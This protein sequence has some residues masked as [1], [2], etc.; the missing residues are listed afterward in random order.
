MEVNSSMS[1]FSVLVV[2][3]REMIINRQN[4][5]KLA[6]VAKMCCDVLLAILYPGL[7][8]FEGWMDKKN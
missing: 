4:P 5:S 2:K 7:N 1:V 6:A 3:C 8:G